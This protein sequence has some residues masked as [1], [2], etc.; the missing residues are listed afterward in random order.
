MQ[1]LLGIV[2][3]Y[4]VLMIITGSGENCFP[5]S[6]LHL[7]KSTGLHSDF[8]T[9]FLQLCEIGQKFHVCLSLNKDLL[10]HCVSQDHPDIEVITHSHNP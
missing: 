9:F 6:F 1:S 10:Y 2:C 4:C 3:E 5:T 8:L 7:N